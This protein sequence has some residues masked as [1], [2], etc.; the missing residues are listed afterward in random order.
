MKGKLIFWGIFLAALG[1]AYTGTCAAQDYTFTWS[2]NQEPVEG[3][4]LYYKK[5]GTAV[6]PFEGTGAGGGNSPITVGK[7][8]TYTITGLE[9][10]TV[11]HF[12][13]TAYNGSDESSYSEIITIDPSGSD[14]T[15][16][17]PHLL[18]IRVN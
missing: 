18:N 15:V 5:G 13:L 3:Y 7:V 14:S 12:A 4:K 9:D 2:A 11:Y 17:V 8:T 1:L 6:L 10:D 16:P